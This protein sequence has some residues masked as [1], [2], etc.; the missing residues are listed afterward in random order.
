MEALYSKLFDKYTKLKTTKF[1][2]L[3]H[4][5]KDQEIKF[6]NYLSAAEELIEHLK[7]DND[8]LHAQVDDLRSEVASIRLTKDKQVDDYQRL[9][10]EESKKNEALCKEIEELQKLQQEGLLCSLKDGNKNIHKYDQLMVP[11]PSSSSQRMTGK[12]RRHDWSE[13]EA[14]VTFCENCPDNTVRRQLSKNLFEETVCCDVFVNTEQ[15]DCRTTTNSFEQP[16]AGLQEINPNKNLIQ[17]LFEYILGLKLS[18]VNHAGRLS[19][20]AL[21]QSSG[22]SFSLTWG[23]KAAWRGRRADVPCLISGDI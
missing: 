5:N 18:T 19:V 2:E 11:I 16:G 22:Y 17:S 3:E 12:R 8:Q 7:N 6:M 20:S 14:R 23:N 21:H 1:S 13:K 9:L 10:L 4:L 15:P